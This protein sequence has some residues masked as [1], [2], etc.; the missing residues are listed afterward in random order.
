MPCRGIEHKMRA[1]LLP[2]L[3]APL[4]LSGCLTKPADYQ[5]PPLPGGLDWQKSQPADGPTAPAAPAP[6]IWWSAFGDQGLDALVPTVL[7]ANNDIFSAALKARIALLNAGLADVAAIPTLSGSLGAGRTIPLSGDGKARN[8]AS[9]SLGLSYDVDLW[10]RIAASRDAAGMEAMASAEDVEAARL[11]VIAATLSTWWQLAYANHSIA[12]AK[13]S[14]ETTYRTRDIVATMLRARTVSELDRL[15]VEQTIESQLST[16]AA[17]ERERDSQRAA[18]AVL[19]NGA[20][21]PVPE[22]QFLPAGT[23]PALAPGLPASLLSR[24]PDLRAAEL[25]LRATLRSTDEKKASYFPALSLSGSV[26]TGGQQLADIL[27]NPIGTLASQ[28]ALPFLNL[29]QMGLTLQVSE[30]QYQ[31]AVAGFQGTVLTALSEVVTGLSARET[32]MRQ[33]GH[34]S[35][36]LDLQRQV[37]ALTEVQLRAGSI[38]LR[39]LLDAQERTR[40]SENA[41]IENRLARLRNEATLYRALGGS[42]T[43]GGLSPV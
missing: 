1:R 4:L 38:P 19:L 29:R 21:S 34:L 15:Q 16:L 28:I 30:T 22:P 8:N 43:G 17:L 10:G 20:T 13:A 39:T 11:T 35:R 5:R 37:Q 6:D 2:C 41:V 40:Q 18:L 26:G 31:A 14:L 9:A 7:A 27:S 24:R 42:P 36:S 33:E 32:L 25:R 23:I 3:I 12:S